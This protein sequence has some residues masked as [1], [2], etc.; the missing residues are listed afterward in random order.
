MEFLLV[1]VLE[2]R[3][4][5][6][7]IE[8]DVGVLSRFLFE[9]CFDLRE[10]ERLVDRFDS[11][12]TDLIDKDPFVAVEC[13]EPDRESDLTER[14]LLLFLLPESLRERRLA[15]VCDRHNNGG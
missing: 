2:R 5:S 12:E 8:A 4:F 13:R 3:A 1:C 6:K 15:N 10:F 7:R 14:R 9:Y 11:L